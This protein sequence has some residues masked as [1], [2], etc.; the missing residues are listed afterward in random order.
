AH[1]EI[2]THAT[3]FAAQGKI[4]TRNNVG[5]SGK[6]YF[7]TKQGYPG[8]GEKRTDYPGG[9]PMVYDPKTGKTRVYPIPVSH[10]G[11]ISVTPDESRGV[12]YISTCA[13]TRP[14][15][16]HFMVLDLKTG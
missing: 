11:I 16:T 14:D 4:H 13:D 15:G 8:K 2:G 5:A 1:K 7:G 6:I 3:G 12:A 9:Y 10:Q